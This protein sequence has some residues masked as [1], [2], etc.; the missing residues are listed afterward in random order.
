MLTTEGLGQVVDEG[1]QSVPRPEVAGDP[2][3]LR[4]IAA[5]TDDA[6][7]WVGTDRLLAGVHGAGE[8]ARWDLDLLPPHPED[9]ISNLGRCVVS[10][11]DDGRVWSGTAG[12]LVAFGPGDE[13]AAHLIG[14]DVRALAVNPAEQQTPWLLAWP[15][16]VDRMLGP[17]QPSER[18]EQPPGL[19][20]ALAVGR[21]GAATA[22][23]GRSRWELGYGTPAELPGGGHIAARCLVQAADDVWWLGT[24]EGAYHL[25]GGRWALAG[26]QPGPGGAEVYG[27]A[28]LGDTLWA[29]TETGLWARRADGWT[30]HGDGTEVRALAPAGGA[31]RLWLARG[32]GVER[33]DPASGAIEARYTPAESGLASR[34]VTALAE[35]AG[36][37][38]IATQ[39]GISRLR[40]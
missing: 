30:R 11:G 28:V 2:L 31:G 12:G 1:W 23:T 29:A 5:S 6:Y 22:I 34:R 19:P 8:D 16:G 10:V 24:T 15:L 36:T 7:L 3:A 33:Y 14:E 25:A 35:N 20:L 13:W 40:L 38:W 27:L 17:G 26:E 21:D 39:A 18:V 4:A 37:L 32:G 9:Q